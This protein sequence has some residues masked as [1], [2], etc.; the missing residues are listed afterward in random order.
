M[1]DLKASDLDHLRRH[2]TRPRVHGN[3]FIQLD[4]TDRIR[5]HVWGNPEVPQQK[6]RSPIHSHIFGFTSEIVVGRLVN[7]VYDFFNDID[8][9]YRAYVPEIRIKEDTILVPTDD[10]G[11]IRPRYTELI[12]AGTSQTHYKFAAHHI[13]ETLTDG[14]SA[15]IITKDGQTQAQG[16]KMKPKVFIPINLE[17]DNDFNRYDADEDML[18]YVIKRTLGV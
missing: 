12:V 5:L 4:L 17:P 9:D 18:W 3:G 1:V 16:A 13:H 8:G 6:V 2:G 10:T 15:T 14:P 7:V 11:F